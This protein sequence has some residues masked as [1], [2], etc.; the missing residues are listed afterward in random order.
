MKSLLT[1]SMAIVLFLFISAV[2]FSQEIKKDAKV[3]ETKMDKFSS[4]TG[5]FSKFIDTQLPD[6]K[7]SYGSAETRIR[8]LINGTESFYFYQIEKKGQY[9]TSIA[10]I[11]YSDLLEVIKALKVLKQ[12]VEKDMAANPD[13]LENKFTTVDGFQVGYWLAKGKSSWYITLEKYGSNSTLPIKDE[14]TLETALDGAKAK[15]EE[16]KK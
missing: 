8:K 15:I 12:D 6:L 3:F 2:A 14:M 16:L 10:S 11:E 4:K 1:R 7:L 13:Y 5:T 9:S